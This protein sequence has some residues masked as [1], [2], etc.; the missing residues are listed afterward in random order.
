VAWAVAASDTGFGIEASGVALNSG[1]F[2][3]GG[4]EMGRLL[5]AHDWAATDLGPPSVWPAGLRAAVQTMLT[6][7]HP[8][9]IFWGSQHLCFYND[10]Y[11]QSLRADK[12]PAIL[13]RAGRL[14]WAEIWPII[15]PQIDQVMGGGEATW[16]EDH[17]VPILRN[18]VIEEVYWTYGYAPIGED[19]APHGVGGVLV[20][21]NETTAQVLARRETQAAEQRWRSLFEQAPGFVCILRGPEHCFEFVNPRYQQLLGGRPLIGLSLAQAV[22]EAAEQGIT[23]L[24]DGVFQSGRAYTAA[25]Q[26]VFVRGRDGTD[27]Q[28]HLDFVYQPIVENGRVTGI[29]VQGSDVSDLVH[30]NTALVEGALRWQALVDNLPGGAV[31]VVDTELRY[32]M[33]AGEALAA[34]GIS[35]FDLVGRSVF[36][37]VH[38]DAAAPHLANYQNALQGHSF[39]VEHCEHGRHYLTRGVPLHDAAGRVN[40]VLAASN[41]ITSRRE[42]EEDLRRARAQLD[43]VLSAAEIGV[44]SWRLND[45]VIHHD[46]NLAR[47]YGLPDTSTSTPQQHFE[48]IHPDDRPM[49]EAAVHSAMQT[50]HLYVREYRVVGV[51]GGVRWLGS[52]GRLQRDEAG[53]PEMLNGLVIDI[54]DLKKLEESLLASDRNKDRFLAVLAHE[55]RSPLAPMLTAAKLLGSELLDAAQLAWCADL[56]TRQVQHMTV[57][58]DDLLDL[59]GIKHGRLR[60]TTETVVLQR[61]VDAAAETALPL[62]QSRQQHLQLDLPAPP[63]LLTADAGRIAQV[64]SNLLTNAAKYTPAGGQIRLVVRR[65]AADA[66]AS[67][68]RGEGEGAQHADMVEIAVVDTGIGLDPGDCARIFEMFSQVDGAAHPGPGG[69]GIGL[70]LVKGL[71]ELHG[72]QVRAHSEGLGCGSVFTVVLPALPAEAPTKAPGTTP[73]KPQ[74]SPCRVLIADDNTDAAESLSRL[75]Q[76]AGHVTHTV[77]DGAAA[78]AACAGFKPQVALLD[79]GMPGLSGYEVAQRLRADPA[80]AG[81]LLVALTGWGFDHNRQQATQAGFDLYFTKPIDPDALLQLLAGTAPMRA[82]V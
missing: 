79:I 45:G 72:G 76:M 37:T 52:R 29:F 31:F 28:V 73:D 10:A 57:L 11:S 80:N 19:A 47:L 64:L 50:G 14:A 41:D 3:A 53:R 43:G 36:D 71:V 21:C 13:G 78:L 5:R 58:L 27:V 33:A 16:H 6:T 63:L 20:L 48:R 26:A 77:G 56:F 39:E 66:G 54:S 4:G 18:G 32:Q 15:G 38:G 35:S 65:F 82:L 23:A 61:I 17:L 46:V 49:M 25:G 24:L 42:V 51:D 81:L 30:A 2:L 12:H 68:S 40:G 69:L 44:W 55:L 60:I 67:E 7:R 8:V 59:S 62:M 70:A 1:R 22:P 74:I 34:A 75:L 9:F